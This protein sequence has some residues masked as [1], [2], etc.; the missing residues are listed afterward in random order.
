MLEVR[1]RVPARPSRKPPLLFIHG[2]Y[3]DAWCWEPYFLPWFAA[4]GWPA[5]ALSLRGH[6]TSSGAETLFIAG[7]D[8][9]VA[10][11]EHVAG[12]L[13]APPVLVGHSMGAA[14]VER[15]LATRPIRGAA[16]LAPVPPAGLLPV[17]ARLAATHP[18]YIPQMLG[19]DPMR[20]SAELLTTLRPFYF[21]DRVSR[22]ILE[23][24]LLHLNGESPRVL[25]DLSLRLH[26]AL[27]DRPTAPVFVMGATE[28]HIAVPDDTRATAAHH[29]VEALILPGGA[30]MLM[31]EPEW[32]LAAEALAAWLDDLR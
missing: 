10:D 27:P 7:L 26:W 16:L 20:L 19:F 15:M 9:Y 31:L 24:A 17:A 2:G 12:T 1:S 4:R 6:G 28:D 5:H 32:K 29:H 30:H 13:D 21:S 18:G 22:P 11:V 8:D 14:V 23:E 3:C 25:L